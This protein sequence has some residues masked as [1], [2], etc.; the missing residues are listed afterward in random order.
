[1]IETAQKD[2]THEAAAAVLANNSVRDL[3]TL[4]VD[5]TNNKLQLSGSVR[6]FYHKQL[7]QEAVRV[8]AAGLTV[9]NRVD[10]AS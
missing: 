3:R 5:R 4:R 10:V 7:A 6:S 8:V 2:L 9:V 1:M